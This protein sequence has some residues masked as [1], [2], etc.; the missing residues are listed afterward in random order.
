MNLLSSIFL[1][2]LQ[3][4]TEFLPVSSSGHL[5][6][7]QELIPNFTQEGVL[8]DVFLHAGTVLAVLYY[9]RKSI[10]KL[11][12]KYLLLLLIGTIP[13]GIVGLFFST[14]IEILFGKVSVV[15][16][17]LLFT[18]IL[19]FLTDKLNVKKQKISIKSSLL[20]GLAQ[21][22][23]IIPGISRSG[24]TIFTGT[25]LGLKRE[26]AAEFSFLLSVPAIIGANILQFFK[27]GPDGIGNMGVYLVGFLAAFI[28]GLMAINLVLKL[29]LSNRFRIFS[30]YCLVLGASVLLFL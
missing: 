4:L 14:P 23:A 9:F 29:L 3:G 25:N 15:G 11:T 16:F 28:S 30:V 10:L 18:A 22:V 21:A 8:F 27:Y 7:A 5:V 17:A 19:N 2:V 13:A 12:P 6:I 20:I 26:K 24:S 1:G